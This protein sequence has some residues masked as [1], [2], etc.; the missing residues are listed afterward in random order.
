M[1]RELDE[2]LVTQSL[3]ELT[4]TLEKIDVKALSDIVEVESVF[5]AKLQHDRLEQKRVVV[6][7]LLAFD[8]ASTGI[9]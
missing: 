1:S 6:Q 3:D 5:G 2:F 9:D 4:V 8:R 7:R